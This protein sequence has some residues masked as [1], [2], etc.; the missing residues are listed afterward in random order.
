MRQV[1]GV[2]FLDYVKMLRALVKLNMTRALVSTLAD[3]IAS[4]CKTLAKKGGASK[5]ERKQVKTGVG[6]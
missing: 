1:R 3:D 4:A 6:Y 2:L 5:H